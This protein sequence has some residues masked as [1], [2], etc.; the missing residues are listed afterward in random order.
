MYYFIVHYITIKI[1]YNIIYYNKS[2]DMLY[3]Y[4]QTFMS[5]GLNYFKNTSKYLIKPE[6]NHQSIKTIIL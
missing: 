5:I 6:K 1:I 2:Y 4:L 3:I